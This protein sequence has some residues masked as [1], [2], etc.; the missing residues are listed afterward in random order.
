[1]QKPDGKTLVNRYGDM[2]YRICLCSLR[3]PADAEDAVQEVLLKYITRAPDFDSEEHRKAWLITVAVNQCRSMLR[4]SSR[5]IPTDPEEL[6]IPSHTQEDSRVFDAL[7]QVPEKF[8][9]VLVLHY[10]EGYKVSEIARIIGKSVSAVK[11][12]LSKGRALLEQIY[13]REYL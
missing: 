2:L 4:K 9:M 3:N 10:V 12:R 11:M 6:H 1:M 5:S 13:R 8:R 7:M